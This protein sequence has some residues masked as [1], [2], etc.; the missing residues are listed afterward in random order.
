VKI[1]PI[2]VPFSHKMT[3]GRNQ[4]LRS[5]EQ[6]KIKKKPL[7]LPEVSAVKNYKVQISFYKKLIINI[8][9]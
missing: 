4:K 3:I 5:K 2:R 1:R 9:V 7:V 6:S 8:L